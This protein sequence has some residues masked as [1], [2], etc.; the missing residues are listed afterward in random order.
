M[1]CHGPDQGP[2]Q[3][4][5]TNGLGACASALALEPPRALPF[6]TVSE[7]DLLQ[8]PT[9]TPQYDRN[10]PPARIDPR[11]SDLVLETVSGGVPLRQPHATPCSIP[12][13]AC[14][15]NVTPCSSR[16]YP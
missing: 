11:L 1:S 5:P 3:H 16:S 7:T 13:V 12:L 4:V 9:Y 10:Q 6:P 14:H 8:E 2:A 15:T